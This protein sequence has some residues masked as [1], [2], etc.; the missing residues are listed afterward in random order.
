VK[1]QPERS[2]PITEAP[3]QTTRA[4]FSGA[5]RFFPVVFFAV[6]FASAWVLRAH[7]QASSAS[8]LLLI[9]AAIATLLVLN[10]R[11]PLQNIFSL[12]TVIAFFSGAS[13]LAA[14]W[15]KTKLFAPFLMER[16]PGAPVWTSP[17][18]WV[19]A[20]VNARAIGQLVLRPIR[21]TS[22][23]GLWL[24]AV[25]S[26]IAASFNLAARSDWRTIS[27]QVAMAAM[28]FVAT[29]PWFIDKR[30]VEPQPEY[31]PLLITGL[32]LFW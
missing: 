20:L 28:V 26:L 30:R 10:Q 32:L 15:F 27:I 13:M 17:L 3:P 8:V 18:L 11:L 6:C 4:T 29:T 25:S 7:Q 5:L 23:Y 14:A 16:F 21:K 19:I 2:N 12:V 24:I 31:Q 1:L 22:F 9:S